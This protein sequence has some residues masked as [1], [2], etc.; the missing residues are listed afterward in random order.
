MGCVTKLTDDL[1]L[2]LAE[3]LTRLPIA[4]ACDLVG[5]GRST[6]YDWVSRG[7]AGE[8]PYAE[9]VHLVMSSR[10]QY[11]QEQLV[12]IDHAAR[13]GSKGDWRAAAWYLERCYPDHFGAKARV[14]HTGAQ[15]TPLTLRVDLL[16]DDQLAT[17]DGLLGRLLN[18]T[19]HVA[20]PNLP[21]PHQPAALGTDPDPIRP[22]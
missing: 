22:G 11:V 7:S 19:D 5:L 21:C 13:E 14:E 1:A 4:L 10:A 3:A 12:A 8:A 17:L 2:R 16:D 15:G 18:G 6:F 20:S 9:F